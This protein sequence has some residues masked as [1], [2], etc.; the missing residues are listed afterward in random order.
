MDVDMEAYIPS[1]LPQ[2]NSIE[3]LGLRHFIVFSVS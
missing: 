3:G 2:L 1:D